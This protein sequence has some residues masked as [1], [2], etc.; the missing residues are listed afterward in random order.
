MVSATI[1]YFK[2]FLQA[3]QCRYT[4]SGIAFVLVEYLKVKL[5]AKGGELC[6]FHVYYD[7]QILLKHRKLISTLFNKRNIDHD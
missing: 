7:Y 2:H 1:L 3:Q 6:S 4:S 5:G